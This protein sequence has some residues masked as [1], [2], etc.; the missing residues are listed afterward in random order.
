MKENHFVL[1]YGGINFDIPIRIFIESKGTFYFHFRSEN[2]S[3]Y[4]YNFL[5]AKRAKF[6][7]KIIK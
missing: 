6:Y 7:Y 1:C 5:N 2:K 4:E 3:N